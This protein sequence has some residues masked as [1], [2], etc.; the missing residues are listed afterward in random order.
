MAPSYR[1]MHGSSTGCF[2]RSL[3][4]LR[5]IP[6]P[7]VKGAAYGEDAACLSRGEKLDLRNTRSEGYRLRVSVAL[8]LRSSPY[9]PCLTTGGLQRRLLSPYRC[10]LTKVYV[11]REGGT[12]HARGMPRKQRVA[13]DVTWC[14]LCLGCG[15]ACGASEARAGAWR[16]GQTPDSAYPVGVGHRPT[17]PRA[18]TALPL[19]PARYCGARANPPVRRLLRRVLS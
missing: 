9:P 19:P 13:C 3:R 2:A 18:F 17:K 1:R 14:V 16:V 7:V 8:R 10:C 5:P 6:L 12:C 4:L 15:V 11:P